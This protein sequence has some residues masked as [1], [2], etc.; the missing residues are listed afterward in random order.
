MNRPRSRWVRSILVM[1]GSAVGAY[2]L[3]ALPAD[4]ANLSGT[5]SAGQTGLSV[6]SAATTLA[7]R[8][9]TLR[10]GTTVSIQCQVVGQQ[11][12][13]KVRSTNRWNRLANGT[14]VSDAY[15]SRTASIA[16]CSTPPTPPTAPAPRGGT[17]PYPPVTGGTPVSA[18]VAPVPYR[19][20]QGFRT[21]SRPTHDGEDLMAPR[22]TPIH[23]TAAGTVVTVTCNA[24][25]NNCDVDGSLAVAGCG[26]YVE[27]RHANN[28]VTRYCHMV[29]RPAVAVGQ[30]VQAN[31]IIGAVGTS[32]NSSGPH[33][34]FEVHTG[35]PATRANAIDPI[36]FMQRAGA[37]IS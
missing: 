20:P 31:Q 27:I 21:A 1:S 11:I 10:T 29:R 23:A 9:Q 17:T 8:T 36:D 3:L 19:T 37:R 33:L 14:Y 35:Y 22:E 7:T 24:S 32:G 16:L 5:V 34:H 6:R 30:V 25:T 2:V 15:V 28:V 13:G 12:G 18:W 26:W 4:A